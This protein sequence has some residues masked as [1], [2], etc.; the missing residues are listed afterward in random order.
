MHDGP[1]GSGA[2]V[3]WVF[4]HPWLAGEG[5]GEGGDESEDEGVKARVSV[6]LRRLRLRRVRMT[7]PAYVPTLAYLRMMVAAVREAVMEVAG[8]NVAGENGTSDPSSCIQ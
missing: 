3:S 4:E 8:S 2:P 5:E 1:G 6:R 7:A